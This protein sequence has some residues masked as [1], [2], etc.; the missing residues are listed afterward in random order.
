LQQHRRVGCLRIAGGAAQQV[1]IAEFD[2]LTHP[3]LL[4]LAELYC[5]G[6]PIAVGM[7]PAVE[8]SW[9]VC[10]LIC[11]AYMHGTVTRH[12]LHIFGQITLTVTICTLV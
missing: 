9:H 10:Q 3:G 8:N 11:T 7:Q 6:Q 2:C 12:W 5:H 4:T 1:L